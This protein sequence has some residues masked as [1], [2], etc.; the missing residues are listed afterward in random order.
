MVFLGY[1]TTAGLF[2]VSDV[3]DVITVT[4]MSIINYC[5]AEDGERVLGFYITAHVVGLKF[6]NKLSYVR[7]LPFVTLQ[8]ASLG[9]A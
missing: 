2:L 1:V 8:P 5:D 3:E 6:W 9:R 7:K 4:I